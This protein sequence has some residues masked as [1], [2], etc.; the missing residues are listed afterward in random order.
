MGFNEKDTTEQMER[1]TRPVQVRFERAEP[2]VITPAVIEPAEY[3]E[4]GVETSPAVEVTPAV[5]GPPV[6]VYAVI[7]VDGHAEHRKVGDEVV[8]AGWDGP[9]KTLK[10]WI[11]TIVDEVT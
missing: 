9:T 1:T 7:E 3:D 6:A 11:L 5:Y 4:E 2:A 10:D 8:A